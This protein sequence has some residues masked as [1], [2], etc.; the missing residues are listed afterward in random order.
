MGIVSRIVGHLAL[1][2][3]L[4]VGSPPA[5][6]AGP[7]DPVDREAVRARLS[8]L[9]RAGDWATLDRLGNEVVRAYERN[10][11]AFAPYR[12][13]FHVLPRDT[14]PGVLE[15]YKRWVQRYPE[16]YAAVYSRARYLGYLAMD[17]RGG[18]LVRNTPPEKLEKMSAM[19]DRARDDALRSLKLSTRPS[20]SYL[21]LIRA[22]RYNGSHDEARRYYLASTAADGDL[23]LVADEYLVACQPRWGG[24]FEELEAL[25]R[26]AKSKG[27]SSTKVTELTHLALLLASKDYHLRGNAKRAES[28]L[29]ELINANPPDHIMG[30]AYLE[31]AYRAGERE[32]VDGI[33]DFGRRIAALPKVRAQ[34]L[35]DL[36]LLLKRRKRIAEAEALFKKA[37]DRDPDHVAALS[38]LGGIARDAGRP[39]D[40]LAYFDRALRVHPSDRWVLASR[41]WLKLNVLKDATGAYPDSLAAARMGEDSAQNQLGFLY[42]SGRGTEKNPAEAVYWWY[43]SAEQ[44]NQSA[45]ENLAVAK[46]ALP[47]DY[48]RLLAEAKQRSKM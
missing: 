12:T 22:A 24:S 10:A 23:L 14:G 15:G 11:N 1:V 28:T 17:A 5:I 31:A 19:F 25:P 38:S 37:V 7:E 13:F 48:D 29:S 47:A 39:Q 33:L 6:A 20:L 34:E 40:A 41:G 3:S 16:S 8:E 43:L 27:M 32:D 21:Q 26:T 9:F 44:K 42:W 2:I 35:Y 4:V 46:R 36:G 18:D 45:V 30:R